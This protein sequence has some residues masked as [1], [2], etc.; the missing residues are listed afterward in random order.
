MTQGPKAELL[1]DV[2][3]GCLGAAG[4]SDVMLREVHLLLLNISRAFCSLETP[5]KLSMALLGSGA[6]SFTDLGSGVQ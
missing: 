4:S 2:S 3:G 5:S 1:E 6:L